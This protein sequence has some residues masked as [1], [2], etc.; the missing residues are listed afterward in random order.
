[1]AEIT[2]VAEPGRVTG[3]SQSRRLRAD[4]RIPAV[5][6]GHGTTAISVSVDGR[7]LRHALSG[8]SGTNQL[9]QLKVGSDTHLALA[10]VLQ[11]HPVRHTVVHV[12]FQIVSRDEVIAADVPIILTGEAKA[13][14]QEQGLVEQQLTALTV[15]ATPGRIPNSIEVD[16]TGLKVGEAIRVGDLPLPS[17]VTTDTPE[18]EIV[19]IAS[20]SR[21]AAEVEAAEAA[22]AAEGAEA[23]GGA[24]GAGT[25]GGGGSA[26]TGAA[27]SGGDSATSE[28]GAEG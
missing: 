9:L 17:G 8:E 5:V 20:V 13:V 6:Y 23:E 18:D 7:E 25:A 14:E 2:L 11:R 10:R 21:V 1:M 26:D 19:V 16:I 28:A 22:E 24:E 4:G 12:D 15:N 27:G 3:S